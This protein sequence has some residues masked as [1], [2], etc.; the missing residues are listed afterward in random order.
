[1]ELRKELAE[2][3]ERVGQTQLLAHWGGLA[4]HEK[5]RLSRQIRAIDWN[6]FLELKAS[7][8]ATSDT[9]DAKRHWE[10]VTQRATSP[11]AIRL[12]AEP[13]LFTRAQARDRGHEA[14][15]A[16]EIGM[17]LVAGGLGTRLGF[18]L[19]K[20]LFEIGPVSKRTLFRVLLDRL[21]AMSKR[22]GKPI[23]LYVMTSSATHDV[24]LEYFRKESFFGLG[25]ASVQLFQQGEMYAVD[26]ER[27]DVLMSAPGEIFSG[28][29]GHGGMLRAFAE[30]GAL[31]D[32]QSRGVRTFFYGQIDNPLLTVCD[33][34]FLGSHLL[35]ESEVTTQV[36]PK[37]DPS[38]RV[39]VVV[40]IDGVAQIV[41]YIDLP[42]SAAEERLSDGSLKLW[43]GSMAV[44][45]FDA[46]FL[47]R[48]AAKGH[49]LPW[50]VSKKKVPHLDSHGNPITPETPNAYRFEKFI[51]DL[52]PSAKNPLVIEMDKAEAFAPVKNDDSAKVDSPSTSRAAMVA[53]H[54]RWL[55][56]AGAKVSPSTSV[57]IHPA[58]AL[59][60]QETRVKLKPGTVISSA[61]YFSP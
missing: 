12:G 49:S 52:L 9:S 38:E 24:T 13:E 26:C 3:L 47:S 45:A 36:V 48:T 40:S 59:D 46:A 57:E 31:N 61:T 8:H 10:N 60:E 19:P 1:M 4:E 51:F 20:G 11:P 22:F 43:A 16:G 35:F 55:E 2:I 29:D 39:G 32:S 18:S 28:P 30:C 56:S 25:E 50:H 27:F 6:E 23:P 17:I 41:E 58:W 37:T 54:R 7:H 53:L 15:A 33:P 34:E 14:L 21:A 42:K 44:H 5:E